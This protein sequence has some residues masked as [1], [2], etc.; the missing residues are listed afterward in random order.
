M[1]IT[2]TTKCGQ[3]LTATFRSNYLISYSVLWLYDIKMEQ[4][5]SA[6]QLLHSEYHCLDEHLFTQNLNAT[7]NQLKISS[8][9]YCNCFN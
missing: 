8:N 2:A 5:H 1:S 6:D 9:Y 4:L 7:E 3:M